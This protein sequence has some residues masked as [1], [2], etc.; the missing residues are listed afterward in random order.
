MPF[1]KYHQQL[2]GREKLP[3]PLLKILSVVGFAELH[4]I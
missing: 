1:G 3:A 2:L 4:G